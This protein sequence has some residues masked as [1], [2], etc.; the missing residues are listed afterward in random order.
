MLP[1]KL[2]CDFGE[3]PGVTFV[4]QN[5]GALV[6]HL[7]NGVTLIVDRSVQPATA[8]DELFDVTLQP[9]NPMFPEGITRNLSASAVISMLSKEAAQASK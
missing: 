1:I 8:I 6:V 4:A 5:D 7:T 2:P 9:F 3:I